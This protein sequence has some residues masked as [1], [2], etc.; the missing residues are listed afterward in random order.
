VLTTTGDGEPA[1]VPARRGWSTQPGE[2][3]GHPWE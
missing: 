1:Y 3:A 2:A